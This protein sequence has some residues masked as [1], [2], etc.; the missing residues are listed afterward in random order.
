MRP[1]KQPRA[2]YR[3]SSGSPL[4]ARL[5]KPGVQYGDEQQQCATPYSPASH[6]EGAERSPAASRSA[7]PLE[8][9]T[10]PTTDVDQ[11]NYQT[12]NLIRGENE[13]MFRF[14]EM[15]LEGDPPGTLL[16]LGAPQGPS[17]GASPHDSESPSPGSPHRGLAFASLS[18]QPDTHTI[19]EPAGAQLTQLTSHISYT[20]GLESNGAAGTRTGKLW[21]VVN[22][23]GWLPRSCARERGALF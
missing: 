16:Q 3:P 7:T 5:D 12:L 6:H 2:R 14:D 8:F 23:H 13:A 4:P 11:D 9:T 15:P 18:M 19:L 17:N 21:G 22:G 10:Y 1:M 20:G